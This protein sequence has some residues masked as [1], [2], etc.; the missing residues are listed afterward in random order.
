MLTG[1]T[2]ISPLAERY[3][4]RM[5]A[6]ERAQ[7]VIRSGVGGRNMRKEGGQR[8][9]NDE[10]IA[11]LQFYIAL[12]KLVGRQPSASRVEASRLSQ[13]AQ[14]QQPAWA[15]SGQDYLTGS[16]TT[17]S[18]SN[19]SAS[20]GSSDGTG[21]KSPSSV[22]MVRHYTLWRFHSPTSLLMDTIY[23]RQVIH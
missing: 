7:A 16:T 5:F 19:S 23:V 15:R 9:F 12:A 10:K 20:S 22:G 4:L 1:P 11:V 14:T 6:V 8:R 2:A 17:P 13:G 21:L 3:A 18:D